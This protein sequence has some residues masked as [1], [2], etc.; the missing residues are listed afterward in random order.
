[1]EPDFDNDELDTPEHDT[2][3]PADALVK[4]MGG[5]AQDDGQQR[6][7]PPAPRT[8]KVKVDGED[9]DVT[10]AELLAGY[11]RQGDYSRKTAA[12]AQERAQ[13][14]AAAHAVLAERQQH[15][16]QLA[17]M[18][19]VLGL[20]LQEQARTDWQHLLDTNPQ[21]YLKQRHLFEQRQ[22]AFQAA[23]RAQAQA[24]HEARHA[25][26][27]QYHQRLQTE[28]QALLDKLPD[29]KDADKAK[30]E[31][32]RVRDYLK[33]QGFSDDEVGGVADHRAVLMARKAMQFD[34]LQAKAAANAEKVKNLPAPRVLQP[35]GRDMSPADGRSRA[36][37]TLAKTGSTDAAADVLLALMGR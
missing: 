22:A 17:Q 5:E 10:E 9:L 32:M 28:H 18:G 29:W 16:A 25:Q 15:Q 19:Q 12:L 2:L 27:Q 20:Q 30:A 6:Q 1:V 26:A 21:E 34:E 35:G 33:G 31:Q 11:S 7:E 24:R 13:L 3:D 36:M 23:Q 14:Q 8:F 37:K 4:L